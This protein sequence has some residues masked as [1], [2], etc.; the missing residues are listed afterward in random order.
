MQPSPR[1]PMRRIFLVVGLLVAPPLS[2]QQPARWLATW[3]PPVYAARPKPPPASLDRVPTYA[4]RTIRQIVHTTL[5]G[6]RLR[7]R[8]TNEYGERPLVIGAVHVAVRDTAAAV[9]GA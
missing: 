4:D 7:I 2:A 5:G 1:V 3:A 8:L 6:E 9:V